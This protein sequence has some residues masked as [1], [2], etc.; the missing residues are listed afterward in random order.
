MDGWIVLVCV[1]LLSGLLS[2]LLFKHVRF[3]DHVML[4]LTALFLLAYLPFIMAEAAAMSGIVTILFAAITMKHY[5]HKNISPTA[6][7]QSVALF[8]FC[9]YVAET[10]VFLS[11]SF[12]AHCSFQS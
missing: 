8:E 7:L 6:Q 3:T 4:E 2:A 9:A 5:T 11:K 12:L 10:A 1:G